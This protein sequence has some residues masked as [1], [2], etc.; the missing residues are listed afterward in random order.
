MT[1]ATDT[2]HMRHALGLARRGLGR[3]WPNPA[4]GCVIVRDGRIVGRGRTADGGRPHAEAVAL[5]QAGDAARG[6]TAYIT[7]EPCAHHGQTPPC[8]EALVAAGVARVVGATGDP[9]PR[10]AGRGLA[11]LREAGVEVVSGVCEAEARSVNAGFLS[12]VTRGRPVVTLKL[13]A[14]LD[15][16]IAT[17]SGE[18]RWITGGEARR[19]VHALRMSHDAV[20]VGAG[21]VRD[22]DPDL[23]VR[24]LGADRQP[25]RVIVSRHLR[26]PRES[27]LCQSA[28]D[29]PVWILCD[30]AALG[31]DDAKAWADAGARLIGVASAGGQVAPAAALAALGEAGLT[32]VF[33][34]GGGML[35]AS[36][37]HDRLVD[38]LVLFSAGKLIGAEGRPAVGALGLSALADAPRFDLV[39]TR[40]LGVDVLQHWRVRSAAAS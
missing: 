1:G 34:E 17:A 7:L 31:S 39:E 13:A 20:M 15:G 28:R 32:R 30:A 6:A 9:D 25:V 18:S 36:L 27:R 35:A 14:T 4:V 5:A 8:A 21:T 26:L 16:R 38:D 10:V 23:T 29:V 19:A 22:D 37:L 12:R 33:C 2:R 40:A 11:I 24:D 3:V